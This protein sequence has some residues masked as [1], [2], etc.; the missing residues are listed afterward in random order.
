MSALQ[1]RLIRHRVA[2][3]MLRQ[4]STLEKWRKSHPKNTI[5]AVASL[6]E[7]KTPD[8]AGNVARAVN[9]VRFFHGPTR[10]SAEAQANSALQSGVPEGWREVG[11]F[12]GVIKPG[13]D[14]DD[15]KDKVKKQECFIA[16]VCYDSPSAPEVLLL[17]VFRDVV[18]RR[19]RLGRAFIELY[20]QVSPFI[21]DFLR[22]HDCLCAMVR[23]LTLAP[24]VSL[25]QWAAKRELAYLREQ[26]ATSTW[27][28]CA[29]NGGSARCPYRESY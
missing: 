21:A 7:W 4:W 6:Q 16:T 19:S 17:R 1:D 15:L 3:D 8:G 20:Y 23:Q 25:I 18:L 27:P 13:D 22:Q 9:Y 10:Q 5:I 28:T 14:L 26:P 24:I 12:I 29:R 11:P 2:S